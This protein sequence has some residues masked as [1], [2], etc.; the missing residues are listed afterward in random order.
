MVAQAATSHKKHAHP[1]VAPETI[2]QRRPGKGTKYTM[3]KKDEAATEAKPKRGFPVGLAKGPL[4]DTLHRARARLL[5]KHR[6][7]T[8]TQGHHHTTS[9]P[10][11]APPPPVSWFPCPSRARSLACASHG[12]MCFVL[13]NI[14]CKLTNF[15][16]PVAFLLD[17]DNKGMEK[18]PVT[19]SRQ[20][21]S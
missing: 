17:P 16:L 9:S 18:K 12:L 15:I 8:Q 2:L 4:K 19:C 1:H 20:Q 3:T 11:F 14:R 5:A 21:S 6:V 10:P 13:V 7:A